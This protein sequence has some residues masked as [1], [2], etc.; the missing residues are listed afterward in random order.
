MK[1]GKYSMGIGDRFGLQGKYQLQAFEQALKAGVEVTPVWNKSN[2]EH[3]IVH[4]VP[5]DVRT[6]ADE[7]V[8]GR[9]WEK[10]YFV[11][12]DHINNSN[13]EKFIEFSDFFTLDVADFIGK[14]ANDNDIADFLSA[15]GK[16]KGNLSIPGI[17]RPFLIDDTILND[18]AGKY[19]YA[20][21]EAGAIY[22]NIEGRKGKGN[23]VAEV[24]MDEVNNPQ[25]PIELFFIMGALAKEKVVFST[26][27]PKFTGRFNKGVD[28]VGDIKAFAKEF[29]EDILVIDYAIKE[30]QLEPGLKLSVHSGSD[31]FSLYPEIGRIIRKHDK[32]IHLKTA[33]TTWLE[34]VTGLALAGGDAFELAKGIYAKAFERRDD[35]CAPYASVIDIKPSNLPS[36]ETVNSWS[37]EKFADSLRHVPGHPDFNPDLR[38]LIHVGYKIAA[39]YGDVYIN[40]IKTH[41]DLVGK[42]VYENIWER[43]MKRIF[44]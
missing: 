11:D 19:L 33:G 13:V 42:Q 14:P 34:E 35:L 28:Y 8:S 25:T 29:E 2:R 44:L 36:P 3:N 21:K 17:E 43:H 20:V 22:R 38:Q 16:Y 27:A 32:G 9:N 7:A 12:A 4:S 15:F 41:A 26:I 10:E 24:S 18:I 1:I 31:K 30:F 6:E 5:G 40:A 39:E 23:F 37:P